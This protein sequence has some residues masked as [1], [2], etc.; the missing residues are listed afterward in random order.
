MSGKA[1]VLDIAI[2]RLGRRS[3]HGFKYGS[4]HFGV[5]ILRWGTWMALFMLGLAAPQYTNPALSTH[6]NHTYFPSV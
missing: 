2:A 4:S 5:W 3:V 6:R 1:F